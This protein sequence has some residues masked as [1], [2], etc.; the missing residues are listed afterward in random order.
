LKVWRKLEPKIREMRD[1]NGPSDYMKNFKQLKTKAE[2]YA[3]RHHMGDLEK[4]QKQ[5]H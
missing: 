1:G 2:E 5:R 4:L 3:K